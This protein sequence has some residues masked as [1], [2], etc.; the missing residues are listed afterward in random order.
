MATAVEL[1]GI[2]FRLFPNI[3]L[4]TLLVG[5]I[6]FA[7]ISWVMIA[8]GG[9]VLGLVVSALQMA[10]EG[11]GYGSTLN[12]AGAL[13]T[14]SL[15]PTLGGNLSQVPSLWIALTVYYLGMIISN[16]KTVYTTKA[17]SSAAPV[18][19]RQSV[20]IISLIVTVIFGLLM[21]AL[22]S[23]SDCETRIGILAGFMLG[24][25]FAGGWWAILNACGA[26]LFPDIHGVMIGLTPGR[27]RTSPVV[28]QK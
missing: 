14:C 13:D 20:G 8:V 21:I 22:R 7:K 25:A 5:G 15:V 23:T 3:L 18:A 10:L 12:I 9:V 19:Q 16:A 28:C 11:L 2:I 24:G 27:L 1:V 6:L 17:A 26:D 4:T